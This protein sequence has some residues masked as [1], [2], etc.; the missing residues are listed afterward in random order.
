MVFHR[1]WNYAF[2]FNPVKIWTISAPYIL[3]F[4]DQHYSFCN[5]M[6]VALD[7]T[8]QLHLFFRF[9]DIT[10]IVFHSMNSQSR[11]W[12]SWSTINITDEEM[13]QCQCYFPGAGTS[14]EQCLLPFI[15]AL[16][17]KHYFGFK[18]FS[19]TTVAFSWK[20]IFRSILIYFMVFSFRNSFYK[21]IIVFS[22]LNICR[23]RSWSCQYLH[24][25]TSLTM[26]LPRYIQ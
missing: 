21:S 23:S 3:I 10:F 17:S 2:L 8:T 7:Y 14:P 5:V 15:T 24:R 22:P 12:I 6:E 20:V 25:W 9:L 16:G 13:D 4:Q 1:L 11:S 19:G 18:K 26:L